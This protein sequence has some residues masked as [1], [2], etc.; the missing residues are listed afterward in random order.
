MDV[1]RIPKDRVA[2]L[3]GRDGSVSK[4]IHDRSGIRLDI[5]SE[6]GDVVLDDSKAFEPHLFLIVRNIVKAIGRGMAPE[7]AYRLF[8][9]NTELAIIDIRD[10][11]GKSSKH[12]HRLRGRIIGTNGKTRALIEELTGCDMVVQGNTVILLG[13]IE[14]VRIAE[15]AVDM[16]LN[17]SEHSSAYRYLEGMRKKRRKGMLFHEIQD[18]EE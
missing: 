3:I 7:K 1:V 17:G 16:I 13:D 6:S 11:S 12:I 5:D 8:Q 4:E 10:Y 18:R 15:V 2:V 9:E 14:E